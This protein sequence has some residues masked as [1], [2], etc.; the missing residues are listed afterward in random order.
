MVK[1]TQTLG[2]DVLLTPNEVAFA[3][4]HRDSMALFVVSSCTVD[5]DDHGIRVSGG[6][7]RV[8]HLWNIDRAALTPTGYYYYL[9][10]QTGRE[11]SEAATADQGKQL[12]RVL[13]AAVE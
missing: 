10:E 9:P 6:E 3:E 1:G 8:L 2:E 5:R 7:V 4:N 13:G 11:S 12:A